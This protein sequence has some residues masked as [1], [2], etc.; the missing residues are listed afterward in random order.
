M[1][2]SVYFFGVRSDLERLLV[3]DMTIQAVAHRSG[4]GWSTVQERLRPNRRWDARVKK[5]IKV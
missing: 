2:K 1:K 4:L 3:E 5:F